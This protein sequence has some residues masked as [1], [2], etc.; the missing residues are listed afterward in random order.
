MKIKKKYLILIVMTLIVSVGTLTY[1]YFEGSILNDSTNTTTVTT[2]KININISDASVVV[3]NVKPLVTEEDSTKNTNQFVYEQASFVKKFTISNEADSLNVCTGL[4]LKIN[5]IDAPLVSQY[6][7][8]KIVRDDTGTSIEGDF[9]EAS[10]EADKFLGSLLFFNS[11]E[12]KSYTMYVWIEYASEDDQTSML[13][14]TLNATLYVKAVDCKLKESCD[15]RTTYNINY[16]LNGGSGCY[17]TA[18][19]A[20]S[21]LGSVCE[22]YRDG[23]NFAGWYSDAGLSTE[24]NVSSSRV[25]SDDVMFYAK[26][27]DDGMADEMT[28]IPAAPTVTCERYKPIETVESY[29]Y[30]VT[31]KTNINNTTSVSYIE[32]CVRGSNSTDDCVWNKVSILDIDKMVVDGYT[33]AYYAFG[34][35]KIGN[36]ISS[37]GYGDCPKPSSSG[38]GS[39]NTGGSSSGGSTSKS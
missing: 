19:S 29:K 4:Y 14:K 3:T 6:F 37:S 12:S 30:K 1:A 21:T 18:V 10:T 7:K 39:G 24:A 34:W 26:W 15:N 17:K 32:Y 16:K 5:S 20:N 33:D 23:Y 8:Y 13:N 25:I 2:G 28:E 22:P 31:L 36:K 35:I 38:G 27:E 11:G 9:S